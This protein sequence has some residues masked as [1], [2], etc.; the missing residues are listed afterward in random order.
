MNQVLIVDSEK[1]HLEKIKKMLEIVPKDIKIFFSKSPEEA[2][3]LLKSEEIDVFVCELEI[4]VMSG[5][6]LF[7]LCSVISPETIRITLSPAENIRE[8][9]AIIN[10]AGLYRLI[11]K[12]CRFAEDLLTPIKEAI[13]VKETLQLL[14]NQ[15]ERKQQELKDSKEKYVKILKEIEE[16][17]SEYEIMFRTVMGVAK[18]NLKLDTKLSSE[19]SEKYLYVFI[20]NIYQAF[21]K[22]Y[23]LEPRAWGLNEK[24]LIEEFHSEEAGKYFVLNNH[25]KE[26]IAEEAVPKMCYSL[27]MMAKLVQVQ[28]AKYKI[29]ADIFKDNE[30][31]TILFVCD[32]TGSRS[33]DGEILY[34][35]F[36]HEVFQKMYKST[37]T[38]LKIITDKVIVGM[39]D[40]PYAVKVTFKACLDK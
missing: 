4:S 1:R 19:V 29:S 6:E 26:D 9:L 16:R 15:K 13:R 2:L 21:I 37:I 36:D 20:E 17:N 11:L 10:R 8:T 34:K 3:H 28:L 18:N 38:T 33:A 24:L 31:L 7:Y 5:E 39:P 32:L 23:I 12:P 35:V 30:L 27:Y 22:Y 40:N 25:L 14:K